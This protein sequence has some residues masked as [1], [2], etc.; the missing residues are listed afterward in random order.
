MHEMIRAQLRESGTLKTSM[1]GD[2]V[3]AQTARLVE[4]MI[5]CFRAG[6]K[7]LVCGNGGSAADAQ[8]F[9]CEFVNRFRFPRPPLP[10]LALTTDTSVMTSTAND[11]SFDHVFERSVRA[12]GRKGDLLIVITTSDADRNQHGHSAN[13]ARAL[14][15]ARESGMTT[16]GLLSAKSADIMQRVDLAVVV[17][18]TD[19]PR[20]QE[21]HMTLIHIVSELVERALFPPE[22]A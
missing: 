2:Q 3:V 18:H 5:A 7:V 1:A 22:A 4:G 20:I 9:A 14:D 15:A 21:A 8:H 10:V 16:A 19:T 17:P 6:G 13:L 12:F 11:S